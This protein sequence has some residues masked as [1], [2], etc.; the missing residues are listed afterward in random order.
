MSGRVEYGVG[1]DI[2]DFWPKWDNWLAWTRIGRWY[3]AYWLA[4][5]CDALHEDYG[6]G[7]HRVIKRTITEEEVPRA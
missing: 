7:P 2:E 1:C 3:L 5:Q 4:G 6:C